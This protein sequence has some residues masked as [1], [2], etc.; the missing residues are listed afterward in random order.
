MEEVLQVTL[1]LFCKLHSA[2]RFALCALG[3]DQFFF[4]VNAAESHH[5]SDTPGQEGPL[6][7]FSLWTRTVRCSKKVFSFLD[8]TAVPTL[9]LFS[10]V[11]SSL[12]PVSLLLVI[13]SLILREKKERREK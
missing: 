13:G 1:H 11:F 10:F 3:A 6:L 12:E 7:A 9:S 2:L 5:S 8:V 4:L